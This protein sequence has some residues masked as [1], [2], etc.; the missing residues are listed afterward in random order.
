MPISGQEA[1]LRNIEYPG[2]G[3]SWDPVYPVHDYPGSDRAW[4][5]DL[6][7]PNRRFQDRFL[8]HKKLRTYG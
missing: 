5:L 3:Y 4:G 1:V 7:P 2:P 6:D 8:K